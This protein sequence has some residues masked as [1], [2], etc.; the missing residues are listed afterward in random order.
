MDARF[1]QKQRDR[2]AH[3]RERERAEYGGRTSLLFFKKFP[4]LWE[5][6]KREFGGR[7]GRPGPKAGWLQ[8]RCKGSQTGTP[9]DVT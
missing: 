7:L 9:E 3:R 2:T 6:E 4:V 1:R 8:I 5:F